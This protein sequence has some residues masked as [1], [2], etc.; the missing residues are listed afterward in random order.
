MVAS[1][2][3]GATRSLLHRNELALCILNDYKGWFTESNCRLATISSRPTS[4]PT[5]RSSLTW[6]DPLRA[7][8]YRFEIISAGRL[9]D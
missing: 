3:R 9:R 1:S 6:P 2:P 5:D 8:A 7:V 4:Q